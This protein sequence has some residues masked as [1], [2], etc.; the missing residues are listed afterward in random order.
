MKAYFL[1]IALGLG[2]SGIASA[3][4]DN[5]VTVSNLMQLVEVA[6]RNGQNVKMFPGVYRMADYLT[7]EVLQQIRTRVD[8]SLPR[9]PVPMLVFGG[10]NNQFDLRDVTIEIDTTLY[11]KLPGR[12]YIR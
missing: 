9:P 12:S 1:A 3:T 6:A 2:L 10:D 4:Q 11:A 8:R 5:I 7:E